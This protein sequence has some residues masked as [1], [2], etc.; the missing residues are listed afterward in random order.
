MVMK[1]RFTPCDERA[2]T[3]TAVL[4]GRGLGLIQL[5]ELRD[6]L[7]VVARLRIRRNGV[8][9]LLD[10]AFAGIVR[11]KYQLLLIRE[12]FGGGRAGSVLPG[13]Y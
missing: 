1:I 9:V 3:A 6:Q 12:T 10:G 5:I 7:H 13:E 2:S 4:G 8:L 11:G